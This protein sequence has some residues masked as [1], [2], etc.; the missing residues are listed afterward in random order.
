M[1]DSTKQQIEELESRVAQLR[2]E[3][4]EY[5]GRLAEYLDGD[6]RES[7]G[8]QKLGTELADI[9]RK[10]AEKQSERQD[11]EKKLEDLRGTQ[12]NA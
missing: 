10:F 4:D 3:E 6:A 9:K 1:T 7:A 12:G 11:A 5:G 8:P 2:K